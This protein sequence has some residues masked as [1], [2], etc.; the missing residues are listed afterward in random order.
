M[1]I[2]YRIIQVAEFNRI[3]SH[4]QTYTEEELHEEI[5]LVNMEIRGCY[6]SKREQIEAKRQIRQY[7]ELLTALRGAGL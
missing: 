6:L 7:N 4:G 1:T 2:S 5:W 3:E